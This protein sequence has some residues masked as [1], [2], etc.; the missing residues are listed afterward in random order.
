MDA[1]NAAGLVRA[2]ENC[3]II[4]LSTEEISLAE[5]DAPAPI[6]CDSAQLGYGRTKM[7]ATGRAGMLLDS[8]PR[9]RAPPEETQLKLS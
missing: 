8:T 5:E 6:V 3:M 7:F 9:Q 4:S 2:A 1:A